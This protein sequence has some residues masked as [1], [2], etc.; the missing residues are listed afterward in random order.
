MFNGFPETSSA[1]KFTVTLQSA[2]D[3]VIRYSLGLIT[4]AE[5]PYKTLN[6]IFIDSSVPF[7]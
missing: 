5:S 1:I 7:V 2:L 3:G 6:N 4:D